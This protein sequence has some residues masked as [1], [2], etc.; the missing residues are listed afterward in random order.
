[1]TLI[2][3]ISSTVFASNAVCAFLTK[4]KLICIVCGFLVLTSWFY[5]HS[6]ENKLF[7]YADQVAIYSVI[8]TGVYLCLKKKKSKENSFCYIV[9]VL[10]GL[11]GG[12]LYFYGK[13]TASFCHHPEF[14][15]HY[16]ALMHCFTS[17]A[18]HA[19]LNLQ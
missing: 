5:H 14:G 15:S 16:H 9:I 17:L 13:F 12:I 19:A 6:I 3:I 1:M 4:K 7:F 8:A 18:H 10:A 11:I 2:N